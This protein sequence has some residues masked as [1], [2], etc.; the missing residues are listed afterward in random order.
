M[1]HF[2]LLLLAWH[3]SETLEQVTLWLRAKG[4]AGSGTCRIPEQG[5]GCLEFV[6][7]WHQEWDCESQQ[8]CPP[9]PEPLSHWTVAGLIL[10]PTD[11]GHLTL[12]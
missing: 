5:G 6:N 1:G 4:G 2:L 9:P 3:P 8:D 12:Y 11:V 10:H 7:G